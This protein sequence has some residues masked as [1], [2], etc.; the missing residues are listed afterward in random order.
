MDFPRKRS[1]EN[2]KEALQTWLF[3]L[4]RLS[5]IYLGELGRTTK[6]GIYAMISNL[7]PPT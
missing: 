3:Y 7:R 4:K 5:W 2:N 6:F 1:H